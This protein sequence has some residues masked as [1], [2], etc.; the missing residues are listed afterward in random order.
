VATGEPEMIL[1]LGAA[2]M[3]VVRGRSFPYASSTPWEPVAE[4]I[5]DLHD[6]GSERSAPE[7][8]A[9]IAAKASTPWSEDERAGLGA[10]LGSPVSDLQRFLGLPPTERHERM[11]RAVSRALEEGVREP[12]LLVL[13]DLHWADRTTLDFLQS[14]AELGLRGPFGSRRDASALLSRERRAEP[15]HPGAGDR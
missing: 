15:G 1:L 10:V 12:T 6:V 2:G 4:L 9:A 7:A 11:V 13:E 5:R 8:V 3:A 14:V